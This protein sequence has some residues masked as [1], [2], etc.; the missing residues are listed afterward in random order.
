MRQV[1]LAIGRARMVRSVSSGTAVLLV[2]FAIAVIVRVPT[3]SQPLVERHSFRQTQTAWT[4]VVYRD[5]GIDL[6]HPITP[7]LG[8]P[9]EMPFEFPLFQA[10]GALLM[11]SGLTP[12]VAMRTLGMGS[13]LVTAVLVSLLAR[14]LAGPVAATIAAS[15]FLFS[16]FGLLW[17]RTSMIEYLATA[18][19]LG[20][21][22]AA[23]RWRVTSRVAPWAIALVLGGIAMLVKPTTAGFWLL[24]FPLLGFA[25]DPGPSTFRREATRPMAWTLIAIPILVT[26]A[27]TVHA[28]A[29]KA[30][31]PATRDLTSTA[32]FTWNFGTLDQ[33]LDPAAWLS[34]SKG[35]V[36]LG[37]AALPLA[38]VVVTGVR[39]TK[40]AARW[41]WITAATLV[42]PLVFFNLYVQHDYYAAAMS[43]GVALLVGGGVAELW[44]RGSGARAATTA[45]VALVVAVTFVQGRGYW[46]AMFKGPEADPNHILP[47]ALDIQRQSSPDE[48]VAINGSAWDPAL[49]FYAGRWGAQGPEDGSVLPGYATFVCTQWNDPAPS[50]VRVP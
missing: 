42:P 20:F 13:F 29:I 5:H 14:R 7:V 31:A 19:S 16:P 39:R 21:V 28:D 36:L 35:V 25:P 40:T 30:A 48:I 26:L 38:L 18:L 23:I 2:L 1:S 4:A 9:W 34:A 8:P 44:R 12:E 47:R 22:F 37:G 41:A 43:P 10:L 15:V 11:R 50:C 46:T 17:G 33:R 32:L 27:W 49:L 24:A 6:L 45:V 3:L